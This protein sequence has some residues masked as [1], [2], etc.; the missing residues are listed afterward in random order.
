MLKCGYL[1]PKL[2]KDT[3][4]LLLH[5]WS[6]LLLHVDRSNKVHWQETAALLEEQKAAAV[7]G[8]ICRWQRQQCSA[9]DEERLTAEGLVRVVEVIDKVLSQAWHGA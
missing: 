3:G 2:Y 7:Q 5:W 4:K 1:W 6:Q 8:A 9:Y